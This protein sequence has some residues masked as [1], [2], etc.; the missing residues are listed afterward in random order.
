M[1]IPGEIDEGRTP[2]RKPSGDGMSIA[3]R[4]TPR[5]APPLTSTL[6]RSRCSSFSRVRWIARPAVCPATPSAAASLKAQ[7]LRQGIGQSAGKRPSS[8]RDTVSSRPLPKQP[9]SWTR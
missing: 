8:R 3:M 7:S 9:L 1:P 4:A 5:V 2:D 6:P